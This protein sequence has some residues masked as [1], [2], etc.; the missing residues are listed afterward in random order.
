MRVLFSMIL[1]FGSIAAN[2]QKVWDASQIDEVFALIGQG[3]TLE[4]KAQVIDWGQ[5]AYDFG[6]DLSLQGRGSQSVEWF[7]EMLSV[8]NEDE[9]GLYKVGLA[10]SYR[11]LG[12][13]T[14]ARAEVEQAKKSKN[15]LV[16]ARANYL[17]GI[18]E[19]DSGNQEWGLE[20]VRESQYL[21]ESL[22]RLGGFQL[23]QALLDHYQ[24]LRVLTKDGDVVTG[25][26]HGRPP[27]DDEGA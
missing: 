20:L 10:W 7:Q 27:R 2:A 16:L 5:S 8:A 9:S 11:G 15:L 19:I 17:L 25:G 26:Y 18:L 23:C 12:Y 4:A 13:S 6:L 1:L 22:G 24:G 14:L 21:Y 3:N